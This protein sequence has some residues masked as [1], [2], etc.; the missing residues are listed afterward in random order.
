M[1]AERHPGISMHKLPVGGGFVG[2]V[3]AAG[4]V[5]IFVLGFPSLW[6]FVALSAAFG[7]G[8]AVFLQLVSGRRSGR[9][10]ALSILA[11]P[12]QPT[13]KE[14]LVLL[15]PGKPEPGKPGNLFQT[16]PKPFSA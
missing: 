9:N 2:L 15:K 5:L 4:C 3:F 7:I 13:K 14:R 8:V 6:Y 12:P 16:L 1:A 11:V 10:K